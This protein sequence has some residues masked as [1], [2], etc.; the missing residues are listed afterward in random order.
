LGL[1]LRR[2]A[3]R[4]QASEK[5]RRRRAGRA[6]RAR[7][8]ARRAGPGRDRGRVAAAM[9]A[10]GPAAPG[11]IRRSRRGWLLGLAGLAAATGGALSWRRHSAREAER[12]ADAEA[13]SIFF[14]QTL[15][16]SRGEVFR[17]ES[18]RGQQ[19]VANFWASWCAPCVE[20]MPE[21]SALAEEV[22]D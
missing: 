18:L 6:V 1:P 15:P 8:P 16:D 13:V 11:G 7:Q 19:V 9:T 17:F 4:P 22:K 20:E 14:Q 21:L 12:R 2:P 5:Q 3:R 10:G